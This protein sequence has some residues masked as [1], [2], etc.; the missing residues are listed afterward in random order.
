M[1]AGV[2]FAALPGE[3]VIWAEACVGTARARSPTAVATV[4]NVRIVLL[5]LRFV[6]HAKKVGIDRHRS[7][8]V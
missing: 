8:P 2:A 7:K 3:V 6:I 4:R 5:H 1:G